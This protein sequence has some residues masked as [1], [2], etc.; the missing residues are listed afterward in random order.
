MSR[1]SIRAIAILMLALH[2]VLVQSSEGKPRTNVGECIISEEDVDDLIPDVWVSDMFY[3]ALANFT[4]RRAPGTDCRR[5]SAVYEIHLRNHTSWA[6][7]SEFIII[8]CYIIFKSDDHN[9]CVVGPYR[10]LLYE[11]S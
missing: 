4:L 9:D 8:L 6:V 11:Q 5:Q 7:R 10:V 2:V 1:L 3:R